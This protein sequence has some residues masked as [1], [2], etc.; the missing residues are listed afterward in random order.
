M[1]TEHKHGEAL[2][3]QQNAP[4][5]F[6]LIIEFLDDYEPA[7]FA[8]TSGPKHMFYWRNNKELQITRIILRRK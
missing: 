7:H 5:V 4:E 3:A 8:I 6:E 1:T 2:T